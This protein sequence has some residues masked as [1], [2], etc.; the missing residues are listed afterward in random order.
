M[1]AGAIH[2]GRDRV[3]RT[4]WAALVMAV[5]VATAGGLI[6]VLGDR[7]SF[8]NDDWYFLF[9]RPGLESKPGI[10]SILAPHNSNL[11]AA[12]A[13]IYKGLVAVFGLWAQAPFRVTL[14]LFMCALGVVMYLVVSRRLGPAIGLACAAVT[15]FLGA[16]W[17]ELDSIRSESVDRRYP[18]SPGRTSRMA[19]CSRLS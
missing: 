6:V 15:L 9:Q 13:L 8:F 12:P 19:D 5:L 1:S 10:D 3:G 11:V 18:Q 17:Q 2:A 16:A 7:L 4:P 14:A